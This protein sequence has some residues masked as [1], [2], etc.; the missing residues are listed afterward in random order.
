MDG[1]VDS[2]ISHSEVAKGQMQLADGVW[3]RVCGLSRGDVRL[4]VMM[5]L[6]GGR[7]AEDAHALFPALDFFLL[8]FSHFPFLA[9]FT[10]CLSACMIIPSRTPWM[11][12][13]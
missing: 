8:L 1:W 12:I 6:G 3:R 4:V 10:F 13:R 7:Y 2:R 11:S 5:Q 9:P